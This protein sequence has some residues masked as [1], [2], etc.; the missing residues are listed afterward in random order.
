MKTT[1]KEYINNWLKIFNEKYTKN[2][3]LYSRNG[4][5][6]IVEMDNNGGI[7]RELQWGT[8]KEL[9]KSID[10]WITLDCALYNNPFNS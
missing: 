8:L 1:N 2:Y 6:C 3:K 5:Y 9:S 7:R 4:S 10:L